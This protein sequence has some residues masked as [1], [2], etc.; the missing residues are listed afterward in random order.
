MDSYIYEYARLVGSWFLNL[1]TSMTHLT[2]L[3]EEDALFRKEFP[4]FGYP[5]GTYQD[6]QLAF[7]H[8]SH[9][10]SLKR[11][12]G[13]VEKMKHPFAETKTGLDEAFNE[14]IKEGDVPYVNHVFKHKM[15]DAHNEAI[16]EVL[17]LLTNN[18]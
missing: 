10:R 17:D 16:S 11:L 12:R 3:A 6:R 9:Q 15:T 14:N 13:E 2:F 5:S 4:A 1:T 8:A 7:L 18:Q